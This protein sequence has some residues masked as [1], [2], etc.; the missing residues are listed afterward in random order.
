M[1]QIVSRHYINWNDSREDSEYFDFQIEFD[2]L[3]AKT[4][5]EIACRVKIERKVLRNGM[6]LAEIG[7]PPGANVNRASLETTKIEGKINRYDVLPDRIIIY[8]WMYDKPLEFNFKFSLRYG[9]NAQTP[10]S[11]VYDY[12]NEEAKATLAP[13]RFEVK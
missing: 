5:E 1:A 13:M 11:F 7:L 9:I 6:I 12:Y 2:K 8:V 4:G 3:R 10:A